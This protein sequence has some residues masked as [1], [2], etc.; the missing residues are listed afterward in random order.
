MTDDL[1]GGHHQP[2]PTEW[3]VLVVGAGVSGVG[4]GIALQ[5][6]S[7]ERFLILERERVGASFARWPAEMRLI[8]PSFN[9]NQFGWPDLNSPGLRLSPAMNTGREHPTGQEYGQFLVDVAEH[10][11]LPVREPIDVKEVVPRAGG[12]FLVRTDKGE[13]GSRF[14]IW[15]AGEFQYPRLDG[16]LGADLCVHNSLIPSFREHPGKDAIVIGGYE[17]GIDAA[18]NLAAAGNHVRVLDGGTP[19]DRRTSDPSVNLAPFTAERLRLAVASGRVDLIGNVR[20]SR[21]TKRTLGGYTVET[22]EG[23]RLTTPS[24]P[25][26]AT[27][28]VSS[29]GLVRD[30]FEWEDG[31]PVLTENDE[32]TAV[33]GLFLAGPQV[34]HK[35]AIFCF[36]YKFRQRFGVVVREI[37]SRLGLETEEFVAAYRQYGMYLDD[38]SCCDEECV[39]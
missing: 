17:S 23:R 27:G 35:N 14:L 13:L 29:L 31:H 25:I 6:A 7:V 18:V 38:L 10:F 20:V 4:C 1:T 30:H 36:I 16:F 26:L 24:R 32:S 12:G 33:T 2:I 28:F 8:T 15:A 37:A 21:V 39:C 11:E 3:D 9:S 5:H 34:R 19:W 22:E